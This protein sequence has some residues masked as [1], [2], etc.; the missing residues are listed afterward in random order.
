MNTARKF[1]KAAVRPDFR[2]LDRKW[3]T[4]W[5]ERKL[6]D[7]TN[8]QRNDAEP[9][10]FFDG[11]PGTNGVPHIG[12]MM[13]SALKDVWPR[14]WTMRGKKVIR[15]AGW[16]THG[17]P[18]EL[19]AEKEL[20]IQTKRGIEA[21]GVQKY[22]DYCRDTVFRYKSKWEEAIE[23]IGREISL[24]DAYATYREPYIQTDWWFLQRAWRTQINDQ[25][26]LRYSD[27]LQ[28][29]F[30][31]LVYRNYRIMP[32]CCRCGTP[33]SN[34]EI[35]QGYKT[36]PDLTLFAKF[37]LRDD[38]N[39]SFVAWT[40]TAWTLLSNVA[41]A[42]GPDIEYVTIALKEA[43]TA[44]KAGEKFIVANARLEA[45]APYLP[46]YD[47][48]DRKSGSELVGVKYRPLWDWQASDA[49]HFVIADTYVTTED[50]SGI[51]HLA[52]YGEDDF[53]LIRQYGLSLVQNVDENGNVLE[54]IPEYGGR[55][56]KAKND[57]GDTLLDLDVL[58]D[59]HSRNLLFAKEKHEHEY[60]F[61][62]RCDTPLMYFARAGW[63]IR[64][65][66]LKTRLIEGN[67]TIRW[68]PEHIRD[69][70]FGNWLENV[71]DWNF[72]RERYWG[73]PLPIWTNRKEGGEYREYCIGSRKELEELALDP[74]PD[75]FDLHKPII[76][77]IR[78]KHPVT[79]EPLY[80]ENFVLDSWFDAGMM[81]WGQWGYPYE[82]GSVETMDGRDKQYPCDFI[83]EAIDQTRGW[84]YTLLACSVLHR[85]VE[86]ARG[87]PADKLPA[88]SSY[89]TVICTELIMD[90][91]GQK[92]S[93][94]KGNVVDP[95]KLFDKYGADPVRWLFYGSNPWMVKKFSEAGLEEG[96][97]QVLLPVWNAYVFFTTYAEADGWEPTR[98]SV[99]YSELDR[100][101][102]VNLH[103]LINK[104]T[105]SL[106][107]FDVAV[108]AQAFATF[109]DELNNW[110]IRRS[111]RRFWK[112]ESDEDKNAAF[113]TLHEVLLT[114]S[115]LLAPFAPHLAEEIY[116]GMARVDPDQNIQQSVHLTVW[117][118]KVAITEEEKWLLE[119]HQMV[120][121]IVTDGHFLRQT[122]NL[123]VRQPLSELKVFGAG[124]DNKV[125]ADIVQSIDIIT[126]ELNVKQVTFVESAQELVSFVAKPNLKILG[127]RLGGK[128]KTVT[129][130]I[131][132][133]VSSDIAVLKAGKAIVV[134]G[135]SLTSGD[136]LID[137]VA[138]TN[139]VARS[140]GNWIVALNT[141]LD[142]GLL[143]EGFVR[144]LVNRLQ[145]ARKNA[146]FH[147]TDRIRVTLWGADNCLAPLD[148]PELRNYLERET[149][150]VELIVASDL[151]AMAEQDVSG[152]SVAWNV[153]RV[154]NTKD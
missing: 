88:F 117:P 68:Q 145:N 18:V 122:A 99:Q 71:I 80:R 23:R 54:S 87:T 69:G 86:E 9:W 136:V 126:D 63:F 74:I 85:I 30:K 59:L 96:I 57:K 26:E 15:R 10:V 42:V 116:S 33:L 3:Q 35:A 81:P 154:S 110:Y 124:V 134:T 91:K 20:G 24:D 112:S 17:L 76:D 104:V 105:E 129:E 56:F 37:P 135:E 131:K 72:T 139:W 89:K 78:I 46:K 127:P 106:E 107:D 6:F 146:D 144:E 4:I 8:E 16:D 109:F 60:P 39:T 75:G 45:L 98:D 62:Y 114:V 150:C 123:R 138:A 64:M 148:Q 84:F 120:R 111:R 79:G 128:L 2:V 82:P 147:V 152:K 53:R 50:G 94:S 47:I 108:A 97:Q 140:E 90:D 52:A 25:G 48:I 77:E 32:Y 119:K 92:M 65:T 29:G 51:V 43:S 100:W 36:V 125:L 142:E 67:Q 102:L 13:Q 12:H 83:C 66:E 143:A 11:P 149:L 28:E 55:F 70:R 115:K 151:G 31:R 14:F 38:P 118:T 19:T 27:E 49:D 95:V 58:K 103:T 40:T 153:E 41:L 22:I 61:C 133:L 121:E 21:F 141:E 101:I 73:S 7:V 132:Q 113:T 130:G 44:G 93:K 1:K 34:F 137:C 5:K